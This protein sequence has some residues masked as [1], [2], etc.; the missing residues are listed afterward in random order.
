MTDIMARHLGLDSPILETQEREEN[1]NTG[2]WVTLI[3]N[4]WKIVIIQTPPISHVPWPL[5]LLHLFCEGVGARVRRPRAGIRS[6]RGPTEERKTKKNRTRGETGDTQR[7]K[8]GN[9]SNENQQAFFSRS[10]ALSAADREFCLMSQETIQKNN[11]RGICELMWTRAPST[12]VI[13]GDTCWM[14]G[15]DLWR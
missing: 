10:E 7:T 1:E 13:L 11:S 4:E 15:H 9:A 2:V 8:C 3:R 5:P 12:W 14:S 6:P